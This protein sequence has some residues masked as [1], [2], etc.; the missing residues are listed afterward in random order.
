[1]AANTLPFDPVRAS[2]PNA[3]RNDAGPTGGVDTLPRASRSGWPS[4]SRPYRYRVA[5]IRPVTV[6]RTALPVSGPAVCT[7]LYRGCAGPWSTLTASRARP[8]W[9]SRAV[10]VNEFGVSAPAQDHSTRSGGTA[11]SDD[12]GWDGPV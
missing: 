5:G 1:M 9:A 7:S 4:T 6:S 8:A 11:R 2:D 3:N 10:T 12:C